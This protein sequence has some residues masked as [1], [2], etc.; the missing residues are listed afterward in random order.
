MAEKK[1]KTDWSKTEPETASVW[2]GELE[3]FFQRASQVPVVNSVAFAYR[4]LDEW[5]DVALGTVSNIKK[6]YIG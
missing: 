1:N 3:P 5:Y 6:R 4:D 2:G